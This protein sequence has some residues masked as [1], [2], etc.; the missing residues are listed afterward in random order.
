MLSSRTF[1]PLPR[2]MKNNNKKALIIIAPPAVATILLV[3]T[4]IHLIECQT[5]AGN[6][7]PL[8]VLSLKSSSLVLHPPVCQ[9]ATPVLHRQGDNPRE[10]ASTRAK[11][12]EEAVCVVWEHGEKPTWRLQ[13]ET[14]DGR[15][16]EE[17]E[18]PKIGILETASRQHGRQRR[19]EIKGKNLTEDNAKSH[20]Q[21]KPR[22]SPLVPRRERTLEAA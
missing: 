20:H 3:L 14:H 9:S 1:P 18:K 10:T 7:R 12:K 19:G 8:C 15:E 4:S 13:G 11:I 22:S 21:P 6:E 2:L 5:V 17:E 16:E